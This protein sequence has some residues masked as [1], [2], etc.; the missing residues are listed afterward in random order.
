M[1]DNVVFLDDF[2]K[3]KNPT[4]F[5][6]KK[7]RIEDSLKKLKE[8]TR[9]LL[10]ESKDVLEQTDRILEQGERLLEDVKRLARTWPNPSS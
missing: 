10:E 8:Q 3:S 6:E 1:A 9:I 7:D 4:G 5:Y 2:R